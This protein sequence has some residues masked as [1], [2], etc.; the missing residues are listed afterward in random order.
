[1]IGLRRLWIIMKSFENWIPVNNEY[2]LNYKQQW[3]QN[4]LH[5]DQFEV[6]LAEIS[7][8]KQ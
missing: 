8:N 2:V 1:M 4:C 3:Q 7:F 6:D 5:V